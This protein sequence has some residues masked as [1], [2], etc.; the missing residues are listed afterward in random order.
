MSDEKNSNIKFQPTYSSL[1]VNAL[2]DVLEKLEA[3]EQHSAWKSLKALYSILPPPC[4]TECKKLFE[5]KNAE[6]TILWQPYQKGG[7]DI[8]W[9]AKKRNAKLWKFYEVAN[10]A[11]TRMFIDSLYLHGYLEQTWNPLDSGDFKKI[12]EGESEQ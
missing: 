2:N 4:L 7:Y 10:Y 6:L 11:I 12:E 1:L 3:D 8:E 5:Q 9:A